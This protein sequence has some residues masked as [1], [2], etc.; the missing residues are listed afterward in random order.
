[1][2]TSVCLCVRMGVHK[3]NFVLH[4]CQKRVHWRTNEAK[5]LWRKKKKTMKR[6]VSSLSCQ[7]T[8]LTWW[9]CTTLNTN[10]CVCICC[11]HLNAVCFCSF[12]KNASNVYIN[13]WFHCAKSIQ[14]ELRNWFSTIGRLLNSWNNCN[15]SV[16]AIVSMN[17]T[18][19]INGNC[20]EF[21]PIGWLI[22]WF[23]N[24]FLAS[25]TEFCIELSLVSLYGFFGVFQRWNMCKCKYILCCSLQWVWRDSIVAVCCAHNV[26]SVMWLVQREAA[27]S[28]SKHII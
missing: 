17:V 28:V 16:A 2:D 3:W 9:T 13:C 1:M 26:Q 15:A 23:V 18:A 21:E 4:V 27:K 14:Y 19:L 24:L 20:I 8:V 11:F 25:A 10:T 22:D 5:T 6:A 7:W 12:T